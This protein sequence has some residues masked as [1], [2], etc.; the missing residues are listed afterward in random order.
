MW[1]IRYKES[2]KKDLKKISKENQSLIKK[3]I[4]DKLLVDPIKF[5]FSLRRNLRGLKKL[6][7]G[8]YRVIFEVKKE[9]VIVIVIK[10]GHRKEVYDD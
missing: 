1:K 7:V 5:G 2:V 4:E 9:E 10:I 6:R 8:D 3:S